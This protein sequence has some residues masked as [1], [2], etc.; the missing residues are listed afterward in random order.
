[1]ADNQSNA[2]EI[3][4]QFHPELFHKRKLEAGKSQKT[5]SQPTAEATVAPQKITKVA[6]I[7]EAP[8]RKKRTRRIITFS[9]ITYSLSSGLS[10]LLNGMANLVPKSFIKAVVNIYTAIALAILIP[11]GIY[12]YTWY[13]TPPH[14]ITERCYKRFGEIHTEFKKKRIAG[15][16]DEEWNTF[17]TKTE[18]EMDEM[19]YDL[20]HTAGVEDQIRQLI[21]W[22]GRDSLLRMVQKKG[23][24]T[25]K[26]EEAYQRYFAKIKDIEYVNSPERRKR[27]ERYG[28]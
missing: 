28:N 13:N 23:V 9:D 22:A 3:L 21:M 27:I 7:H 4:K 6:N 11:A 8:V 14:F 16:S 17:I 10:D 20:E 5:S 24:G 1:M 25:Q 2:D 18:D 15:I 26:E 12:F 19:I